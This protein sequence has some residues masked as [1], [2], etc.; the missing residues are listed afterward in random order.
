MQKRVTPFD[1]PTARF[2][3]GR[4]GM[5][6]FLV[7][8]AMT[9]ASVIL[10]YLVVRLNNGA[11]FIPTNAPPPP[12]LLLVSSAILLLSSLTMQ[13]ALAAARVQSARQA[14]LLVLTTVLA[15]AFLVSQAVAWRDLWLQNQTI[16]DSLY[17]WT[18]YVLTGLHAAHVLGGLIPLGMCSWRAAHRGY[19]PTDYRGVAYCAMYW[20]FLTAVWLV[21]YATL[22]FGSRA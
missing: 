12:K 7:V 22:W 2:D 19:G 11:E 21:M 6:L 4:L 14:G 3:A 9:F 13:K 1:D 20:H 15:C 16:T 18:F 17:A 5:W 10:G 8:L